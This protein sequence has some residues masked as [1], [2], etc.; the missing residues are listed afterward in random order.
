MAL[1]EYSTQERGEKE[2]ASKKTETKERE[3][4]DKERA[5]RRAMD[6]GEKRPHRKFPR[7]IGIHALACISMEKR[8]LAIPQHVV[9]EDTGEHLCS[10][11]PNTEKWFFENISYT[12]K[13]K[14]YLF[15]DKGS[16]FQG[17]EGD[18]IKYVVP[19]SE[20][21]AESDLY[22]SFK[23]LFEIVTI[24]VSTFFEFRDAFYQM[25]TISVAMEQRLVQKSLRILEGK[26][27][28]DVQRVQGAPAAVPRWRDRRPSHEL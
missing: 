4:V 7:D 8:D 26:R 20:A 1:K 13:N 27:R 17:P 25:L 5:G 11:L 15:I 10:A 28:R 21:F 14:E 23:E 22:N 19:Y 18:R 6:E 24:P 3:A 2:M 16:E 12:N 9:G